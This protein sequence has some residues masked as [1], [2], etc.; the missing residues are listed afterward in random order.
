MIGNHAG[1]LFSHILRNG[2]ASKLQFGIFFKHWDMMTNEEQDDFM[3]IQ[4]VKVLLD[5]LKREDNELLQNLT[6]LAL[7]LAEEEAAC[8]MA[9][10]LEKEA[11]KNKKSED[12]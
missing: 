1:C 7:T 11:E 3:E 5:I 8:A 4:R 2:I 12:K 6:K 9:D 10:D